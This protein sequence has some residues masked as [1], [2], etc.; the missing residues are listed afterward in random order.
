MNGKPTN[1]VNRTAPTLEKILAFYNVRPYLSKRDS[2]SLQKKLHLIDE[3][4]SRYVGKD[5]EERFYIMLLFRDNIEY[6]LPFD[7]QIAKIAG[8]PSPDV[9]VT[10]KTGERL[11][12]EMKATTQANKKISV[13]RIQ[14]QLSFAN[15]IGLPLY[16][17]IAL[18]DLWGLFSAEFMLKENGRIKHEH[19]LEN[20]K[21]EEIF[22]IGFIKVPKGFTIACISSSKVRNKIGLSSPYGTSFKYHVSYKEIAIEIPIVMDH[23]L[24]RFLTALIY[25]CK[26]KPIITKDGKI[27]TETYV[28]ERTMLARDFDVILTLI[29]FTIDR[30]NKLF[31]N[32][33]GFIK[34]LLEKGFNSNSIYSHQN[35]VRNSIKSLQSA[36]IDVEL[37]EPKE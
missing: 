31:L 18:N 2:Q 23:W 16:Y 13:N 21:F 12:I 7:E 20:S 27:T 34:F 29:D 5:F 30:K 36:G 25:F 10:L 33:G 9:L 4:L 15:K 35:L 8:I 11:L 6:I 19:Y 3:D 37:L 32:A 1:K 17:L 14:N 28:F 24:N 22:R 26:S